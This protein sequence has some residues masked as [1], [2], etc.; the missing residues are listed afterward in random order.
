MA[1]SYVYKY[2]PSLNSLKRHKI[3]QKLKCNMDIVII[4]ADKGNSVVI[5]N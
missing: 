3:I 5:L 4:H 2:T 1:N